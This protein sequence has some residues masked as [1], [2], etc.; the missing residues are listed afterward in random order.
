MREPMD[1]TNGTI[2]Q[3]FVSGVPTSDAFVKAVAPRRQPPPEA[4]PAVESPESAGK[5]EE[6]PSPLR[7]LLRR[8]AF[9]P[10]TA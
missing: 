4:E 10:H 9:S 2:M 1:I 5:P 8:F 7:S 6:R 3:N